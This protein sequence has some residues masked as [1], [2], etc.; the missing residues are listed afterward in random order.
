MKN[1][2]IRFTWNWCEI[3][4]NF[5]QLID[6][7]ITNFKQLQ[8][9]N[10]IVV[11]LVNVSH[12]AF[13]LIWPEGHWKPHNKAVSQSP[14]KLFSDIWTWNLFIQSW[15][16]IIPVLYSNTNQCLV[17]T[18]KTSIL[19][20]V[21]INSTLWIVCLEITETFSTATIIHIGPSL[22]SCYVNTFCLSL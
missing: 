7:L 21:F 3:K 10:L 11:I 5:Y 15:H 13:Y 19:N 22:V 8:W 6:W 2:V 18:K 1:C 16:A 14:A 12:C 17:L 20:W 9:G 4:V